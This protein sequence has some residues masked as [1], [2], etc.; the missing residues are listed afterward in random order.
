MSFEK[1]VMPG[2]AGF[3]EDWQEHE[4]HSG[5]FGLL[6]PEALRELGA[7]SPEDMK[8]LVGEER[9]PTEEEMHDAAFRAMDIEE[10]A[11]EA[12]HPQGIS[13]PENVAAWSRETGREP[14]NWGYGI[15]EPFSIA[16]DP[17]T[18]EPIM[19]NPPSDGPG[20]TD[21]PR[22]PYDTV[23]PNIIG[24]M[25]W[26]S[27]FADIH[28][29]EPMDL[30]WRLL[31][32]RTRHEE[33]QRRKGIKDPTPKNIFATSKKNQQQQK[34]KPNLQHHPRPNHHLN[35]SGMTL[36]EQ[37]VTSKTDL[38]CDFLRMNTKKSS[39]KSKPHGQSEVTKFGITLQ[40]GNCLPLKEPH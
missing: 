9:P 10:M 34:G 40:S 21:K 22:S 36:Q 33:R 20:I 25:A 38:I 29:S 27:D 32:Y 23:T 5:P 7:Y 26:P 8:E 39:N 18:G 4:Q 13:H 30:S 31:K 1:A 2:M 6:G 35:F 28:M 14:K 12:S 19:T 16:N 11:R 37:R 17:E 15:S 3:P 24:N